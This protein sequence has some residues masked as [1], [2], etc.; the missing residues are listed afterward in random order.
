MQFM[1]NDEFEKQLQ[2]ELLESEV[3]DPQTN[4]R[5]FQAR[6]NALNAASKNSVV[7]S[8]T[9]FLPWGGAITAIIIAAVVL[10]EREPVIEDI[11]LAAS[12][13][14]MIDAILDDEELYQDMDF[15]LWLADS[16]YES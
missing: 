8:P 16:D 12:E 10:V 11:A 14:Q 6:V 1:S 13:E 7:F 15:Y 9:F 2:T 3:L 4:D 5:L